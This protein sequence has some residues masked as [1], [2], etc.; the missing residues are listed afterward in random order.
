MQFIRKYKN[1]LFACLTTLA[2]VIAHYIIF[3]E[4]YTGHSAKLQAQ[5]QKKQSDLDEFLKVQKESLAQGSVNEF[6]I[7]AQKELPFYV[8]IF[9][10]DSLEYW[11]TNQVPIS[12]FADIHFPAEGILHLQN[13]WYFSKYLKHKEYLIC[14]SFL[15]KHEYEYENKEL[16]N[17]F[18]K[19]FDVPFDANISLDEENQYDI[20]DNKGNYLFSI[21]PENFQKISDLNALIYETLFIITLIAWLFALYMIGKGMPM[22]LKWIVPLIII[23]IWFFSIQ[24]HWTEFLDGLPIIDKELYSFTYGFS[25]FLELIV[26]CFVALYLTFVVRDYML[27]LRRF[28]WDYYIGIVFIP[29]SMLIWSGLILIVKSMIIDS[30]FPLSLDQLFSLNSFSFFA[31]FSIGCFLY[32]FYTW[33]V[34]S[35]SYLK[36]I[37]WSQKHLLLLTAGFGI[38][39]Y[40]LHFFRD[41]QWLIQYSAPTISF[42]LLLIL[43]KNFERNNTIGN[44]LL[45]VLFFCLITNIIITHYITEKDEMEKKKLAQLLATEQ[46]LQLEKELASHYIKINQDKS[47]QRFLVSPKN[48]GHSEFENGV[49]NRIFKAFSD[50][51]E[52]AF[53]LFDTSGTSLILG[54]DSQKNMFRFLNLVIDNHGKPSQLDSSVFFIADNTGQLSYILK[55]PLEVK[56]STLNYKGF[57]FA[58]FKS[59]K[60]PE[61]IGFPRLLIPEKAQVFQSLEKYSLATYHKKRLIKDYG[62]YDYPLIDTEV[63]KWTK[64]NQGI[65]YKG[66]YS[67]FVFKDKNGDIIVLSSHQMG[68]KEFITSFAYLFCLYCFLLIPLV[69]QFNKRLFQRKTLTLALKIQLVFVGII[70]FALFAFGWGSGLFV[71]QQYTSYKD[72]LI[73]EKLASVVT[74]VKSKLGSEKELT[75]ESNGNL[76]EFILQKFAKV[77]VTDINLYDPNGILLGSSRA[78]VFNIG[79]LSEQ[80]NP[81]A[82]H[83]M[84]FSN[85]SEFIHD[86][87]IGNLSYASAYQPLFNENKKHLG[88]VNLQHFAQQNDFENQIQLFLVAI[89]NVFI[90][91]LAI[92]IILSIIISRWVTAPL[93]LI[94]VNFSNLKLGSENQPIVYDREDEIGALVKNYNQKLI[95]LENAAI[96]LAQNERESAWREMAKQ[97]AH[98]IKNPLTPMKLSIQQLLRVYDPNNPSSAE[99]LKKV[100]NSMIEQ[101][102]ALTKIANEFSNFAKMPKQQI[103][104]IELIALIDSV[105]EVYKQDSKLNFKFVHKDENVQILAD[106]DQLIRVFNNLLSNAVQSIPDNRKGEIHIVLS[107][108]NDLTYSIAII[109]NGCGISEDK[110]KNIFIPYFTTKTNG[111]GLGLAMVKQIVES[112][113]GTISFVSKENEG[114]TFTLKLPNFESSINS[115]DNKPSDSNQ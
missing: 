36:K 99:M 63:L 51:Y 57:L 90:L 52:M 38:I 9:R 78:K 60:L 64:K 45:Y 113:N 32:A 85:K 86:E 112:I 15:I 108:N 22:K 3:S 91:L 2:L 24:F 88:Y 27:N 89:I 58:T 109:D 80:M 44:G 67:H 42:I 72:V 76:I 92:S 115:Q 21:L 33:V 103:E 8:H 69:I 39:Y 50:R 11:N 41:G 1:L 29:L 48:M 81:D 87:K 65:A 56:D 54:D 17:S 83:D 59:K 53:H 82:F 104:K 111:T 6:W 71:S 100:A 101:I 40:S 95:E 74:E 28:S 26:N 46:D 97:V 98:E 106:K 23:A 10:N 43:P 102:D 4:D 16:V 68:W 34:M 105:L 94:Q 66:G 62:T 55:H 77:F 31:L 35:I 96:Q 7:N 73:K 61:E 114:T 25:N 19:A 30:S 18:S 70:T 84:K 79:L 110:I 49:E 75:I 37:G 47:L 107:D 14:A 13:G 5:F 12:R 93:R 20:R